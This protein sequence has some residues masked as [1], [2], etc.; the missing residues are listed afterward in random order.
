[1]TQTLVLAL[2]NFTIPFNIETDASRLAIGAMLLQNNH[3]ITYFSKTMCPRM[4]RALAYI[5]ELN[6]ITTVV[7]KWR[8]YLL[9]SK[10]FI[11]IDQKSLGNLMNQVA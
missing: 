4:Q 10:F 3:P 9:R 11:F 8:Q 7:G 6:V 1:M 2:S 5:R